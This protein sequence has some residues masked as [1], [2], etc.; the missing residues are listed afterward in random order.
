MLFTES[1]AVTINV[2]AWVLVESSSAVAVMVVC[3]SASKVTVLSDTVAIS[4]S[5]LVSVKFLDALPVT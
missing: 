4:R 2:M 5:E 1:C 3:P